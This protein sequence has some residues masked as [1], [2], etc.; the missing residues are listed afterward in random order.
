MWYN[1]G[2][3]ECIVSSRLQ[4]LLFIIEMIVE[5]KIATN[6]KVMAITIVV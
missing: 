6:G 2:M 3:I 5:D 4:L 1:L